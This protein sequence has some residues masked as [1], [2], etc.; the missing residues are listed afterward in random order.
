MDSTRSLAKHTDG[1]RR[2]SKGKKKCAVGGVFEI[3]WDAEV[4]LSRE[5]KAASA[6]DVFPTQRES[7]EI[8]T[9]HI[10]PAF[11]PAHEAVL[12]T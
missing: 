6:E 11:T 9:G 5:R 8:V 2:R 10:T 7:C 1:R 4:S 3:G 12:Y